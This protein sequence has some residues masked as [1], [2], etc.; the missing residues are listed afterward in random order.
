MR[1]SA[2]T[3]VDE[4]ANSPLKEKLHFG[5]LK[6]RLGITVNWLRVVVLYHIYRVGPTTLLLLLLLM[7]HPLQGSGELDIVL[8]VLLHL[9]FR[10]LL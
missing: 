9:S 7:V 4:I 6:L 5:G 3:Q 1:H 2:G 10:C 8:Q